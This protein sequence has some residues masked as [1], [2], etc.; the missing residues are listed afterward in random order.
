M[1]DVISIGS[2]LVDI[3]VSSQKF[4]LKKEN[5]ALWL[6]EKYDEKVEVDS[7]KVTT[8]GGGSNT[9]VGFA[10]MGFEVGVVSEMGQDSWSELI[11]SDFK[12][13]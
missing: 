12:N 9:A 2:S 1:H 5:S 4:H 8:G 11:L 13:E 3:F 10:R 7:F 6:C